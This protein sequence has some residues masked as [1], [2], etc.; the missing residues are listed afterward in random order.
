MIEILCQKDID[1]FRKRE[2]YPTV[3]AAYL[4]ARFNELRICLEEYM[5]IEH[6]EFNL[7]Q[8][9]HMVVLSPSVDNL[10]DLHEIG[11]N[12][13]DG[14]LFGAV[15]E[16]VEEIILPDDYRVYQIS[17][18][19]TN[20]YM[21][22]FYVPKEEFLK[23]PE[24]SEEYLSKYGSSE[25]YFR[26]K[27]MKSNRNRLKAKWLFTGKRYI[28]QGIDIHVPD[29]ARDAIWKYIED[30]KNSGKPP[31][32]YL[33]IFQLY[34]RSYKGQKVQVIECKQEQPKFETELII[35]ACFTV[36]EKIY[37][38]DDVSHQTMMLAREY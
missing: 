32:D 26:P 5:D 36:N 14:G 22:I 2:I 34:Q 20:S 10:C 18:V 12:P 33:Q 35:P 31:L 30:R 9:G 38:I 16:I 29:F 6:Q 27:G 4:Q 11:L 19:Y 21:M 1:A 28:T 17:V 7:E 15:P 23:I 13:E 3:F 25:I 24:K 37:V 8:F